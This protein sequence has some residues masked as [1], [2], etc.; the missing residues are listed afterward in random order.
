MWK[1]EETESS[2]AADSG[3]TGA[4]S[5]SASTPPPGGRATIGRSITLKGEV[6][7][8]EDLVIQGRV[9]GSVDLKQH[10]VE[11]GPEGRV[12]ADVSGRVV[13]VEGHVD[14]NLR[15]HERVVLRKTAHVE[16]DITSPRV[17][18]ED[19]AYFRGGVEMTDKQS[20][21]G[22]GARSGK[23]SRDLASDQAKASSATGESTQ[24]STAGK[25]TAAARSSE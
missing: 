18:L 23:S 6:T 8:D 20:G 11:I 9:E 21:E 19:G 14:G 3:R 12:T 15:A 13:T 16:G 10:S 1:K 17:T 4:T 7:G 5:R 2:K 24:G 25:G 22:A